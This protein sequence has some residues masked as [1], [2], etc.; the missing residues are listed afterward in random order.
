MRTVGIF[1]SSKGGCSSGSI[2]QKSFAKDTIEG[3]FVLG[4]SFLTVVL[5][6]LSSARDVIGL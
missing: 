2:S 5:K 4:P 6:I 3:V 1:R